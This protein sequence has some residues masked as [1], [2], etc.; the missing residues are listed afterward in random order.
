MD[1]LVHEL[2]P[3]FLYVWKEMDA[4]F[5]QLVFGMRSVIP[6]CAVETEYSTR[7]DFFSSAF[8]EFAQ[9]FS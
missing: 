3:R 6:S 9:V 7:S 8:K 5:E 1:H 4:L 2:L